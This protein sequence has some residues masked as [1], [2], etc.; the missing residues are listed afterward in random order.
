MLLLLLFRCGFAEHKNPLQERVFLI[1]SKDRLLDLG[2]LVHHVFADNG[3]I[4]LHRHFSGGVLFVLI[5]GV[6]MTGFRR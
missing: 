2:F 5:R 3:I 4:F 1:I 6:E